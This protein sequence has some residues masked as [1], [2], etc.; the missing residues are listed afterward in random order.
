[1]AEVQIPLLRGQGKSVKNADYLDLLPV[2]VIPYARPTEKSSGYHRFFPGIEKISDVDG[3]SRGSMYNVAQS[4]IYRVMGGK[5]YRSGASVAD[6]P[7]SD[8]V[9]MACSRTSQAVSTGGSL[10]LYR[11]D[12][13]EKTF[14]NWPEKD[15]DSELPNPQY[16]WGSVG[17]V[18]RLR[19]RYAFSQEGTDTFWLSS[20]EDESKPDKIAP[21]YRA[22]SQ[23]DGIYAIKEWMDYLITFGSSTIEYFRLTGDANSLLQSQPSYM[24][25]VGIA[26]RHTVTPYMNSF[27]FITGPSKGKVC[28]AVMGQGSYSQISDHYVDKILM[29]YT[30]DQLSK[31]VIES[32][33][34]EEKNLLI[35]HL[36]DLTLVFDSSTKVWTRI[37]TGVREGI[38]TAIDYQS[39]GN[40]I[41]VGDQVSGLYGELSFD[42]SSQYGNRQ[43]IILYSPLF[44]MP[45]ATIERLE[46]TSNTSANASAEQIMIST[47]DN[48]YIWSGEY[49]IKGPEAQEWVNRSLIDLVGEV[50]GSIG[51]RVRITGS[52]PV[53]IS[54]FKM[55]VY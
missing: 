48:G 51:F 5:L 19:G 21:A 7:N 40:K 23:P 45:E 52:S 44:N 15:P 42:V 26:G 46:I 34:W 28:I 25:Q 50:R 54:A 36:P 20:L 24:V 12:G 29:G 17:D 47:T 18:T 43:E 38:H 1:M 35:A 3:V 4:S 10:H 53:T 6:V 37:K 33:Q 8:R 14:G 2:N 27:A 16:N 32:V 9:S 39:D 13:T 49:P 22:E 30:S 55:D 31:C 41:T 11:Y